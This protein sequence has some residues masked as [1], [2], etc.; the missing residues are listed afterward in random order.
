MVTLSFRQS[1]EEVEEEE[2]IKGLENKKNNLAIGKQS[3]I[4]FFLKNFNISIVYF[5]F[6][7]F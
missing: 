4:G 3:N 2:K 6:F 1:D 7:L 5:I